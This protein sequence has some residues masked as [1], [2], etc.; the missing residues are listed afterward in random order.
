[1]VALYGFND[2]DTVTAMLGPWWT[3]IIISPLSFTLNAQELAF[4][5][6]HGDAKGIIAHPQFLKTAREAADTI[7][8]PQN[9]ILRYGSDKGLSHE[10]ASYMHFLNLR[11]TRL[12]RRGREN[13]KPSEDIAL[14]VYSSG[15]TGLPKGVR[16]SHGNLVANTVQTVFGDDEKPPGVEGN[17]R[18]LAFLPFAHIYRKHYAISPSIKLQG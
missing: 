9:R 18:I 1:M 10:Q 17:N 16:L 15:T 7:G 11:T 4:Q 14:I 3:G 12:G 2:I 8:M 6:K 5:L 13:I